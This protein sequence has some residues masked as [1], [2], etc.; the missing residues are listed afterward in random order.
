MRAAARLKSKINQGQLTTGILVTNHLW[1]ELVEICLNAGLD[2][3]IIDNEHGAFSPELMADVCAAGRLADLAVLMRPISHDMS[4]I[5][6]SIDMGPCGLLLP[7]VDSAAVLDQVRDAVY[8][9][10]RGQR[11]PGGRGNRWVQDYSYHTWKTEV[12]DCL[13]ILPQIETREGLANV[14]QIASH[15]LTT[16]MAIGPYDLSVDL[17]V[18]GNV[19]GPEITAATMTIQRAARAAGKTM[20]VI[21]DGPALIDQGFSFLCIAE[22]TGL[23]EQTLKQMVLRLRASGGSPKAEIGAA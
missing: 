3:M 18:A 1:L 12:E 20:W 5:R 7:N 19:S 21:G 11:R 8:M 14:G 15:E 13:I 4:T 16:A 17:G 9:P 6:K 23:L 10:P 2:Y 22:P